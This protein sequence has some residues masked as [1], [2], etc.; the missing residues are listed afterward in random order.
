MAAASSAQPAG[1]YASVQENTPSRGARGSADGCQDEAAPAAGAPLRELP[2]LE[3]EEVRR[4]LAGTLKELSN[5]RKIVIKNLPQDST[6]KE[7]HNILEAYELKYCY[8]DKNK[9]TAFVTLLNGEQAQD[10]IRTFHQSTIRGREITVQLQPT[11]ALLCVAN[12]PHSITGA[13]FEE[14]VRAYGNVERCFL[15]HSERTGH[16]KGY[17]FVEY[18]K[19]ESALR[20]RTELLGQL[21]EGRALMVQWAD[22]NHLTAEHLHSKCLC[23]DRIPADCDSEKLAHLFGQR[24]TPVFCQVSIQLS[25]QTANVIHRINYI[26]FQVCCALTSNPGILLAIRQL[27]IMS[28]KRRGLL[29]EPSL[30]QLLSSMNNPAA[31]Q[32]LLRPYLAGSGKHTG[33]CGQMQSP[34]FL[35]QPLTAALIQLGKV[36]QNTLLGNNLM[37]Q[38][39]LQMQLAH[40]QLLQIKDKPT[41]TTASLL[42]DPSRALLQRTMGLAATG[43]GLLGDS[44]NELSQDAL[45]TSS[46]TAG[47]MTYTPGRLPQAGPTCTDRDGTSGT[48]KKPIT[49][50]SPGGSQ[51][52]SH[53]LLHSRGCSNLV[54]SSVPSGATSN[55]AESST[56]GM[57][58]ANG[59]T[60]L[61]G[62]PPKDVKLPSIPYLNLA[63]VL[64]GL[65][66][67]TSRKAASHSGAAASKAIP[68]YSSETPTDH[69]QQYGQ[70]Y[71]QELMQWHQH[72]HSQGHGGAPQEGNYRKEQSQETA[73][74]SY[75]DYSSYMQAV[76]QYYPPTHTCH[77]P[78]QVFHHRDA[79]KDADLAKDSMSSTLYSVTKGAG[80]TTTSYGPLTAVPGYVGLQQEA[81][82]S[83][84]LSLH[85]PITTDWSQYYYN[86]NQVQGLKR[87]Y[88]QLQ[89]GS[90]EQQPQGVMA[91]YVD[92][93]KKKRMPE[94]QGGLSTMWQT[95]HPKVLENRSMWL[96]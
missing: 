52:G 74:V 70:H 34:P 48:D 20:A 96:Q 81:P 69:M 2:E 24:H 22:V 50:G 51:S 17:G 11:D 27:R 55:G 4:R 64:P 18:M 40:Q 46:T 14:L 28:S 65:Q 6:S 33:K 16:P 91:L 41:S 15:V 36:Q 87:D 10:A 30:A 76:N 3:P 82:S 59:Q 90:S 9:G 93:C 60:S 83:V 72:Y 61:L 58:Q 19:K 29:P 38:N 75:M 63:S 86:Q 66:A 39:L 89:D 78:A 68:L 21:L 12:L 54:L 84:T 57:M 80:A 5:R 47:L 7:V 73:A 45:H 85:T 31:L 25:Q 56:A 79:C 53:G 71:S 43:K 23:V 37:F 42:G 49:P 94:V 44:P 8:V 26:Y 1:A 32:V 77:T 95:A 67:P 88:S 62:E 35:Q 92:Q 13:R